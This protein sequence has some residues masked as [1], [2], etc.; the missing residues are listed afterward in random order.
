MASIPNILISIGIAA[1]F[2]V[3]FSTM[4]NEGAKDYGITLSNETQTSFNRFNSSFDSITT[5]GSDIQNRTSGTQA[6]QSSTSGINVA[7]SL[8]ALNL[9]WDSLGIVENMTENVAT[10]LGIPAIWLWIVVFVMLITI[11]F[12]FLSAVLSNPL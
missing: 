2:I 7:N 5:L 11:V 4:I 3:S 10:R 8:K 12:I 9:V 1:L 6:S